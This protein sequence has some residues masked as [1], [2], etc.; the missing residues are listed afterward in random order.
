MKNSITFSVFADFHYKKDMYIPS[1]GDMREIFR[2]AKRDGAELVL[3]LGDMCNDYNGSPEL[4]SAYLEND[5]GLEV[6]G[7]FGNHE[8][9][10]ATNSMSTTT[11]RLTNSHA[12]AVFG[13]EDGKVGDGSVAYYYVDKDLFRFI[14]TDTNYSVN[15]ES[16]EFEHNKE[17]SWGAP[18][19]NK[20]EG[21]LGEDQLR[22][23]ESV[24]L[25]SADDGKRCIVLSHASFSGIWQS[26]PDAE[27]VRELF[28]KANKARKR[29]VVLAMNGHLHTNNS[30][31]VEDVAYVDINAVRIGW[32]QS[33][34][35]YPYE[36]R[37]SDSPE[38]TYEFTNYDAEGNPTETYSRPLSSIRMG[39]QTLF[40]SEPLSATVTVTEDGGVTV[41]GMRTKWMYG[42]FPPVERDTSSLLEI[43]DFKRE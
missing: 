15:P 17:A 19:G 31:V 42:K 3:H 23:L 28:R 6:F 18:G 40:Y 12:S 33:E 5:A 9:E 1:V 29:T 11:K 26:S 20:R 30:A 14:F 4:M 32:W 41:K 22:W 43:C 21:S 39:A 8:L 34:K 25:K 37:N 24:L 36:E 38:F 13:T 16:G 2:R 27:R 35:F 7:A 10:S